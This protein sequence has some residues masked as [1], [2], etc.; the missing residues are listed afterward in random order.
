MSPTPNSILRLRKHADYQRV[1][2]SSRKQ[3]SKQMTFFYSLRPVV[4]PDGKARRS[5]TTG[6][7][8]GLTVGKVMGKAVDRNRIKRRMRECIR[9]SAGLIT[10]P[11][12]VILHPR[13]GVIELEFA[14]LE[15]EVAMVFRSIQAA[16][17][18]EAGA[19][20]KVV[21]VEDKKTA[22]TA[23]GSEVRE[24]R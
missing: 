22:K 8:I 14:K 16:I 23:R 3:F 24:S 12:D 19:A 9:R 20:T 1:Y 6:P 18:K 7:R 17:E 10:A 5:D 4:G 11:V 13:R 15:R 2:T 21:A